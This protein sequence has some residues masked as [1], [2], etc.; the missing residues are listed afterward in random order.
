MNGCDALAVPC[1]VLTETSLPSTSCGTWTCTLSLLRCVGGVRITA[2]RTS[3]KT[4]SAGSPRPLPESVIT[5]PANPCAG[6]I[7]SRCGGTGCGGTV[8]S[9][10]QAAMK[11]VNTAQRPIPRWR[12]ARA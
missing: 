1:V 8:K 6:E 12:M 3:K 10:P 11:I 2:E 7:E 4:E 9:R 5:S